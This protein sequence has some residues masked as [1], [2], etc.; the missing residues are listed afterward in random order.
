MSAHRAAALSTVLALSACEAGTMARVDTGPP[1][2][3]SLREPRRSA[4]Y[5]LV[6]FGH[7]RGPEG[8]GTVAGLDLDGR[9]SAGDLD[10][11]DCRD[12]H[13]D[14]RSPSAVE[15]VDNQLVAEVVPFILE[16]GAVPEDFSP[17]TGF[18]ARI[19]SGERLHALRVGE[20]DDLVDDPDVRV[21]ILVVERLGCGGALCP[22]GEVSERDVFVDRAMP[23]ANGRG[24]I[25]GGRL[26]F[27]IPSYPLDGPTLTTA[28]HDV[29][30]DVAIDEH[31]LDGVIAGGIDIA[32]QVALARSIMSLPIDP[33]G[34]DGL[35]TLYRRFSDL[36]PSPSDPSICDRISAGLE[37][38]AV[39]VFVPM[40]E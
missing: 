18:D 33:S 8:D 20:L 24:A 5:L 35:W 37:L 4:T 7:G 6:H 30:L 39:R 10:T 13:A 19:F 16:N 11:T 27:T 17:E 2:A 3:T 31:H 21:E 23:V 14:R 40:R 25:R 26:R 22:L 36:S 9:E 29:V 1:D 32:E 12:R 15:G 38:E 34:D 28:L